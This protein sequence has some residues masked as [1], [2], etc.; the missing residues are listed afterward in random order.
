M[1]PGGTVARCELAV[2][3]D[4]DARAARGGPVARGERERVH[5]AREGEGPAGRDEICAVERD[6]QERR[7]LPRDRGQRAARLARGEHH[8]LP[9]GGARAASR[10][11]RGGEAGA[12]DGDDRRAVKGPDLRPKLVRKGGRAGRRGG[13]APFRPPPPGGSVIPGE[14]GGRTEGA[15]EETTGSATYWKATSSFVKSSPLVETRTRAGPAGAAG[16]AQRTSEEERSV[17]GASAPPKEQVGG[18]PGRG[19]ARLKP[20]SSTRV[21]PVVEPTAGASPRRKGRLEK[22]KGAPPCEKSCPLLDTSS[23]TVPA[24]CGG[25]AHTS[26]DEVAAVP[27]TTDCPNLHAMFDG[28]TCN[29]AGGGAF[30]G[31]GGVS[32]APGLGVRWAA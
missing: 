17:P 27:R 29:A 21:P 28:C 12:A 6:F 25:D 24:W 13:S 10:V 18:A 30:R 16:A 22:W 15:N 5:A 11:P 19:P 14:L 32:A 2:D 9:R 31:G 20:E 4:V 23:D 1:G 8:Q 3:G 7:G 26:T